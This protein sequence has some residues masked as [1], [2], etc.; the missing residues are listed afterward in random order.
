MYA[1]WTIYFRNIKWTVTKDGFL[2]IQYRKEK[3]ILTVFIVGSILAKITSVL[4]LY[5]VLRILNKL[6]TL[7]MNT[8]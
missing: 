7:K 6:Y 4:V 5:A 2:L 3:R 8:K 1:T